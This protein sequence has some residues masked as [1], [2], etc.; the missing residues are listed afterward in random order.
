MPERV[1]SRCSS[2]FIGNV[3]KK[4]LPRFISSTLEFYI[5]ACGNAAAHSSQKRLQFCPSVPGTAWWWPRGRPANVLQTEGPLWANPAGTSG[6]RPTLVALIGVWRVTCSTHSYA[7]LFRCHQKS[8]LLLLPVNCLVIGI[9]PFRGEG[10][11]AQWGDQ[12]ILTFPSSVIAWAAR[13][14]MPL[15]C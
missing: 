8:F 13:C 4:F 12:G 9:V 11:E 14:F 10:F 2:Y 15:V 5:F 1:S 7:L 3:Y 6:S